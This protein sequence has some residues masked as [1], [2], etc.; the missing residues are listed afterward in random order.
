MSQLTLNHEKILHLSH[1]IGGSGSYVVDL[2]SL[3]IWFSQ[4]ACEIFDLPYEHDFKPIADFDNWVAEG[5]L[6]RVEKVWL[7]SIKNKSGGTV[8]YTSDHPL[9]GSIFLRETWEYHIDAFTSKEIFIGVIRDVTEQKVLEENL[10]MSNKHLERSH[11]VAKLGSFEYSFVQ[12]KFSYICHHTKALLPGGTGVFFSPKGRKYDVWGKGRMQPHDLIKRS[13]KGEGKSETFYIEG[14]DRFIQVTLSPQFD[15]KSRITSC[16]GVIQDASEFV[17]E[18]LQVEARRNQLQSVLESISDL[19]FVLNKKSQIVDYFESSIGDRPYVDKNEFLGKTFDD[20]LPKEVAKKYSYAVPL[21]LKT[22]KA[23]TIEYELEIDDT[24][25]YYKSTISKVKGSDSYLTVVARNVTAEVV[26]FKANESLVMSLGERVKE[27]R[28]LMSIAE[29][30]SHVGQSLEE[31]FLSICG[32]IP[33]GFLF[34]SSTNVSITFDN[35]KYQLKPLRYQKRISSKIE[36]QG[37]VRGTLTVGIAYKNQKGSDTFFIQEEE[38]LLEVIADTISLYV[39][40]FEAKVDLIKSEIKYKGIIENLS[41]GY[42]RCDADGLLLDVNPKGRQVLFGERFQN[43]NSQNLFEVIPE[44]EGVLDSFWESSKKQLRY[45]THPGLYFHLPSRDSKIIKCSLGI[46]YSGTSVEFIEGTFVDNTEDYR[47]D[48]FKSAELKLYESAQGGL[49]QLIQD[50]IDLAVDLLNSQA[51]FYHHVNEKEGKIKLVQWSKGTKEMCRIPD[52]VE[53]YDIEQAG[54]WVECI[55]TK[56]PVIH[57]E[58][59]A[60]NRKGKLPKGHFPIQRDLE[61]PIIRSGNVV[62]I[63]GVGNKSDFYNSKDIEVLQAFANQFHSLVE[64]KT[65]EKSYE[66]T[67]EIFKDSQNVGLIGS[68]QFNF[69]YNKTWWSDVMFDIY[70][71]TKDQGIPEE[72]WLEYTHPDDQ[73]RL[74]EAFVNS[75]NTGH[76]QCNYRLIRPDGEI[77]HVY[78]KSKVVYKEDGSPEKHIGLLQDVTERKLAEQKIIEQN[79]QLESMIRSLNGVTFRIDDEGVVTYVSPQI[80]PIMGYAPEE[81]VGNKIQSE[82]ILKIFYP[83]DVEQELQYVQNMLEEGGESHS[84]YRMVKK[85]GS[86]IWV[87]SRS[88]AIEGSDGR[89]FVQGYSIEI[90][91]KVHQEEVLMSAVMKASDGEKRRISKEI[92]DGLQQTLTIAALNLEFIKKEKDHLSNSIQEKF[93]TGWDYLK[94][95]MNETRSIAHRLMPKAIEDFGLTS[96]LEDMI[97]ELNRSTEIDFD[98]LTNLKGHRIQVGVETNLYKLIQEAINNIIKHSKAK[99]VTIQYMLFSDQLQLIVEDDGKGFDQNKLNMEKGFGLASMKSRATALAAEFTID[100]TI[101]HGTTL[102][103]EIPL[104]KNVAYYE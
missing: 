17:E 12:D 87:D 64:K 61:I 19:I 63:L 96:V 73:E 37:V 57:N 36:V 81:I 40:N 102:I 34:P 35:R 49:D 20:V 31:Y 66:E 26:A 27:A 71:I 11:D 15:E 97:E 62:A 103:V 23:E 3:T 91:D 46:S 93:E 94:K 52:M 65:L 44:L 22:G 16:M 18:E 9:R 69:I 83:D 104:N 41:E 33:S 70:G 56:K 6:K 82:S 51:G 55:K 60:L 45:E 42:F 30:S 47:N 79:E 2:E 28:C 25:Q 101:N 50:G 21:V 89:R 67:I 98:F 24:L 32:L 99:N 80:M 1:K 75:I 92:H 14:D 58:Y 95:G 59:K 88:L 78:A 100:S 13:K 10:Q 76:Y 74:M 90:T 39:Q 48:A 68:W 84:E 5:D 38:S 72:D 7:D 54:I 86:V 4:E 29:L 85:D 77:R 43:K 53:D 8:N